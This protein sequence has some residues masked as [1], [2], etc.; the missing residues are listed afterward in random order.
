MKALIILKR[1]DLEAIIRERLAGVVGQSAVIKYFSRSGKPVDMQ[2]LRIGI[3]WEATVPH[4]NQQE[5]E[6]GSILRV[7]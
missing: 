5:P 2:A 1:A 3:E 7:G 4:I 6:D